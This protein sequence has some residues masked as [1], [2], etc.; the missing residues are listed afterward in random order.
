MSIRSGFWKVKWLTV[1]ILLALLDFSPFPV[2]SL[3]LLY[4]FLFKPLWFKGIID[5]IYAD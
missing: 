1:L 2:S 4:V 5:R 3:V